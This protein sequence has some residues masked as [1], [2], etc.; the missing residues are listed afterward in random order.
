MTPGNLDIADLVRR[1]KA[2]TVEPE[3][4]G[5]VAAYLQAGVSDPERYQLLYILGRGYAYQYEDLI[6]R[7]V[8]YP[9]DPWVA[10]CAL[11]VLC[12]LWEKQ[13]KYRDQL[14]RFLAGVVWDDGSV[15]QI[16]LT[17]AGDYLRGHFD[18]QLW[19]DLVERSSPNPDVIEKRIAIDSLAAALGMRPLDVIRLRA[20]AGDQ[21]AWEADVVRRGKERLRDSAT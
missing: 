15:R 14:H 2:G 7:Y 9:E 18:P 10:R 6:E 8:D 3:E 20:M 4:L 13:E 17:A 19:Q 1:S 11:E 16:A 12:R 5:E 21:D